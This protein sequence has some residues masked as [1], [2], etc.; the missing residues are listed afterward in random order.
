M[1]RITSDMEGT[2]WYNAVAYEY[3][4]FKKYVFRAKQLCVEIAK[5]SKFQKL[6]WCCLRVHA[7]RKVRFPRQTT[8]LEAQKL[9][10]AEI[11]NVYLRVQAAQGIYKFGGFNIDSDIFSRFR[12]FTFRI[13]R[14]EI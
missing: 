2:E 1:G 5:T 8:L 4:P 11:P 10:I 13:A 6:R 12:A 3:K 9:W 14:F 7:V